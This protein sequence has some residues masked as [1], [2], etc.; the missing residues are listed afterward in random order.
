M[1]QITF[2]KLCQIHKKSPRSSYSVREIIYAETAKANYEWGG[3]QIAEHYNE[4]V[5]LLN[6]RL[7]ILG[8][9]KE[10]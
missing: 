4:I 5:D 10:I 8:L 2:L 6:N 1:T 3:K 7:E 9:D